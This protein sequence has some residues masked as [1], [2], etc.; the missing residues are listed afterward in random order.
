MRRGLPQNIF[1]LIIWLVCAN[2]AA[3]QGTQAAIARA[4]ER[5]PLR[6]ARV[7]VL[8]R[9]LSDGKTLYRRNAEEKLKIASN[10]K[11][12]TTAAALWRLGAD[13][14][15]RTPVV[16]DG[17][18]ANGR[19]NGNL[20]VVGGGD[21]LLSSRFC[22]GDNLRAPREMADAL[23]AAGI[24]EI[25]GDL[26]LNERFFDREL[27]APGWA[28][29]DR[30]RYYGAPA[31]ALS[32]NDNC[33]NITV[34]GAQRP[35]QAPRVKV[36]PEVG[37]ARMANHAVTVAQG[38][39][40]GLAFS[41]G[42]QGEYVISGR[43][44]AGASRGEN[45]AVA[46]PPRYFAAALRQELTRA[47]IR[48]HGQTRMIRPGETFAPEAQTM[49][50]WESSL[51][52]A[53]KVANQRSQNFF[54]E[55]ILKTLGASKRGKGS[56]V[57][58]IAEV[59]A[60]LEKA[61][62]A[63]GSV[64]LTDGCGLAAENM[65]TPEAIV[66]LLAFMHKSETGKL[67]RDSLAVNGA[68]PGT[69]RNRLTEKAAAGRIHGKTGTITSHGVSALSGYAEA[70]ADELVAFCILINDTPQQNYY[71]AK[72]LENSVCRAILGVP[73]PAKNKR[74]TR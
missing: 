59:M 6:D 19:L 63:D 74:R 66:Q 60:F 39:R 28:K 69:L 44:C 70:R 7:A 12:F 61:N 35:G 10:A 46:D 57:N 54:A 9:R 3:A 29:A 34:T 53:I 4:L 31:S 38:K 36:S 37:F 18:I 14:T 16:A 65:A 47:G 48:L 51:T 67:F 33:L 5:H 25:S 21:P 2:I 41:L 72:L 8:V 11:L 43:I 52:S 13:F 62:V 56:R 73:E 15:F 68:E 50:A 30:Q 71:A 40:N 64:T 49:C 17:P 45:L 42:A 32:F 20:M 58:G 24:M 1:L 22:P 26:V 55:Q 27:Y 23:K